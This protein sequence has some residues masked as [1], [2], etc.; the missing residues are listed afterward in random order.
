M[1]LCFNCK[2]K[3][4]IM[5]HSYYGLLLV[6]I[7][8]AFSS[9]IKDEAKNMEA[10][11]ER[12]YFD[13]EDDVKLLA[14]PIITNTM[15]T[16]ALPQGANKLIAPHFDLTPG[17]K[18]TPVSGTELDFDT[19]Q[20]YTVVSEDGKWSKEYTVLVSFDLKL[21]Y[22]FEHVD[23]T[24]I[25]DKFYEVIYDNDEIVDK[26]YFWDSGNGGFVMVSQGKP[27]EY[28]PTSA[29]DTIGHD[30][31]RTQVARLVTRST[32]RLGSMVGKPIAAGNLFIGWFN[33][34]EAMGD[35][36]KAT[37][38]GYPI[39]KKPKAF[40]GWYRYVSGTKDH[41]GNVAFPPERPDSCSIYAVLYRSDDGS[42]L[43][44]SN[45]LT[46]DRVVAKAVFHSPAQTLDGQWKQ[47][48][49]NP[50]D[51]RIEFE[52]LVPVNDED[53]AAYKYNLAVVF[54]SS[55]DGAT[56]KGAIDSEL[57]IDDVE[58]VVE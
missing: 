57:L 14:P 2:L 8:L 20:K 55:R 44:G 11:I 40:K 19:P 16:L 4:I 10:D 39:N 51:G 21:K 42:R 54:S 3:L 18:I 31:S 52:Y 50:G 48:E 53:L 5:K 49:N 45:I 9:C 58:I 29:V 1:D 15:V 25:Y 37:E 35:A 36:L 34:R 38:F 27:R 56:F 32:G 33:S 46:S 7:L 13:S 41:N 12:V 6:G 28:Y 30:G 47:F 22:D 23:R 17:A 43:D 26:Q 24:L